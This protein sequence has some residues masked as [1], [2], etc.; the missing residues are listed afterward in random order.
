MKNKDV[1]EPSSIIITVFSIIL[2]SEHQV[3]HI[4]PSNSST[5][6][7]QSQD[8]GNHYPPPMSFCF[9]HMQRYLGTG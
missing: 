2:S 9:E 8:I 6:G 7:H 1:N 4:S 3:S 5:T